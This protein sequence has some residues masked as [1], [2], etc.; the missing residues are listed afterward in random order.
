M[1]QLLG[2]GFVSDSDQSLKTKTSGKFGGNFGNAYLSK[3]AYNPNVAKPGEPVRDAIEVVVSIGDKDYK[4]WFSPINKVFDKNNTE[5][6]DH[7]SPEYINGFNTLI[8]QQGGTITHYL[9]AVGVSEDAIKNAFSTPSASFGEYA[10]RICSLLPLGYEKKAVDV[11]LEYQWGFGKKSDGS[12]NDKT[13][14]TLPKNMKGGYFI[15]P[16]Q[17]GVWNEIKDEEKGLSYQ[18]SN[19]QK[20][21][22]ERDVNFMKGHKGTQQVLGGSPAINPMSGTPSNGGATTGPTW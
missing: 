12:L 22:F 17:P 10:Q 7:T 15:V 13:F 5:I 6:N 21:P 18:N 1:S 16:A 3:F 2:Y 4:E 19:A 9:K 20:H 11:F 8:V 14:P